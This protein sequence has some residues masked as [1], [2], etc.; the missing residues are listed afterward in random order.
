M[1]ARTSRAMEDINRRTWRSREALRWFRSLE[2]FIDPGEQACFERLSQSMRGAHIL[3]LGVGCGRT[4]AQYLGLS[5]HYVGI[6]YTPEMVAACRAKHPE[7]EIL[8]GDARDLS[9]FASGSF[10]LVSFSFNG[11]DAVDLDG[12]RRVMAEAHRVLKP[13][14]TFFFSTVN[15]DGPDFRETRAT[16]RNLGTG[17]NPVR[18]AVRLARYGLG[19]TRGMI[20]RWLHGPL[21]ERD[22]QH[23]I[24]MHAAH[25]SGILIYA[26][27]LAEVHEQ[28][29]AAGFVVDAIL[30]PRTGTLIIPEE[31][32]DEPYFQVLARRPMLAS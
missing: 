18:L 24:L 30:S 27:T 10:D 6:D 1:S 13:G 12:R 31:A 15:R 4:T 29:E 23:S 9:D 20:R 14:G 17:T 8:A 16:G 3:D 5:P 22:G 11:I 7:A 28:L 26:T 19:W 25:D 21:E 2:G 32:R